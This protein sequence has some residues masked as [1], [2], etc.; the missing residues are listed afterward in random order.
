[1]DTF[2]FLD[3]S[4]DNNINREPEVFSNKH[5]HS[6]LS[7]NVPDKRFKLKPS[8]N[9]QQVKQQQ[10]QQPNP[11][12]LKLNLSNKK[13]LKNKLLDFDIN[14]NFEDIYWLSLKDKSAKSTASASSFPPIFD[15]NFFKPKHGMNNYQLIKFENRYQQQLMLQQQLQQQPLHNKNSTI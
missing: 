6:D 1:M 12:L 9:E 13:E 14:R 3:C 8:N 15:R 5:T 4:I 10:N 2:Q 7:F 11:D